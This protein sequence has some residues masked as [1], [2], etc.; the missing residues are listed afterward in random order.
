MV[1]VSTSALEWFQALRSACVGLQWLLLVS[2]VLWLPG[3]DGDEVVHRHRHPLLTGRTNT[4]AFVHDHAS[5]RVIV[6][7]LSVC[8]GDP[9][10]EVDPRS[11]FTFE[12]QPLPVHT[13]TTNIATIFGAG[14]WSTI[15]PVINLLRQMIR[16]IPFKLRSCCFR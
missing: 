9:C 16:N 4:V 5:Q 2:A 10:A 11:V 7:G 6:A 14:F 12:Y 13:N 8:F 15:Y 3:D 1:W